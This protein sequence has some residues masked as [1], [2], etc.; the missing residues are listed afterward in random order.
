MK[1]NDFNE[2]ITYLKQGYVLKTDDGSYLKYYNGYIF[3]SSE[4][5]KLKLK[6]NNYSKLFNHKNYYLIEVNDNQVD[7][8]KDLEYYSFRNK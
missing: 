5:L 3:L 2:A 6:L 4:N 7:Y 8:Q 1:I